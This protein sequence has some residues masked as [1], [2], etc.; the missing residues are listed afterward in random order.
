MR[1]QVD[2]NSPFS[3]FADG[4][5]EEW[6]QRKFFGVRTDTEAVEKLQSQLKNVGFQLKVCEKA[7]KT[8]ES[9]IANNS[10]DFNLPYLKKVEEMCLDLSALGLMSATLLRK[11]INK[12]AKK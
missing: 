11:W 4:L 12:K 10:L 8:L 2:Q 1:R 6:S 3:Q 9:N 7:V 5:V